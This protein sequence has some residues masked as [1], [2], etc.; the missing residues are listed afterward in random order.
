MARI[1]T[2]H[3]DQ[4]TDE[5][6]DFYRWY[7]PW[8]PLTPKGVARLMRGSKIRWWIIG[9]WAVDAFTGVPRE[10]EDIDVAFFRADLPRLIDH[11][12]PRYCIWSNLNGTLRPLRKAEDL[13]EGAR[14]LWVRRD[15]GSP[16]VMDLAMNPHDGDTWISVRDEKIQM[17]ID[18]ATF[19]VDGIS[20]LRPEIVIWMKARWDRPKDQPDVAQVL[21]KLEAERSAWLRE[22]LEQ[23]HPGHRWLKLIK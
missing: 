18:D 5:D 6:R 22:I 19:E 16:W 2:P 8:R 17:P 20:Y 13:L 14:Q 7:G 1:T 23:K 4:T 9:G 21:P 10:H 15:G 3:T 11:L 12:A